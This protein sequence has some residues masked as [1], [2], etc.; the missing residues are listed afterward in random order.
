MPHA[1]LLMCRRYRHQHGRLP[2]RIV[3]RISNATLSHWLA[4]HVQQGIDSTHMFLASLALELAPPRLR[5]KPH[6]PHP[7]PMYL[8]SSQT[9]LKSPRRK[10]LNLRARSR[11]SGRESSLHTSSTEPSSLLERSV[12]RRVAS[13][14]PHRARELRNS[15]RCA[16]KVPRW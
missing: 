8:G 11:Q 12:E 16:V 7:L 14:C 9:R 2:P 13:Y 10:L 4:L 15:P 6:N 5:H 1:P 3:A